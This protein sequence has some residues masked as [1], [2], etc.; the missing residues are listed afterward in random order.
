MA[1]KQVSL[2]VKAFCTLGT[3]LIAASAGAAK[4][5]GFIVEAH[6]SA[7]AAAAV[8]QV[9]GRVT[10]DLPI[11]DGVASQLTTAQATRLRKS[12][13]LSLF[14][15]AGATP[16][17]GPDAWN[18]PVMGVP[19]LHAQGIN[20]TGVT[21]AVIDTGVGNAQGIAPWA[22]LV[23]VRAFGANGAGSYS[24][25]IAGM[26]WILTHKAQYN[27]RVLNLSFGA[28]P[29]SY[30]WND[31]INQAAMKLWQAGIVVV[32]SAGN[33]GPAEQTISVPGN[34]P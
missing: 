34:T 7:S 4:R 8:R 9:G 19:Q 10:R 17:G 2:T 3:T 15:D 30:Y 6:D 27:I 5:S 29:Q 11:I 26:N 16:Q 23:W 13:H 28:P 22:K 25:V 14:P 32:A 31:P 20:G 1:N 24:N 21:V 33:S 12:T 18:M